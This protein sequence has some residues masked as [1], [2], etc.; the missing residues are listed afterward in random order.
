MV[1]IFWLIR[2]VGQ[3]HRYWLLMHL[4]EHLLAIPFAPTQEP[5]FI[6]VFCLNENDCPCSYFELLAFLDVDAKGLK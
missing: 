3:W 2:P 4:G 6:T 1:R 5:N